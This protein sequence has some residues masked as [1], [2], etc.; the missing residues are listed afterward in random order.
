M[1]VGP[2]EPRTP[3]LSPMGEQ[4][5]QVIKGEQSAAMVSCYR[6]DGERKGRKKAGRDYGLRFD[7]LLSLFSSLIGH[8]LA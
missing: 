4:L 2:T 5:R 6:E 1:Q 3:D 7:A 8:C